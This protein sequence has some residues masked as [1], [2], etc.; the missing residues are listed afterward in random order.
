MM[1]RLGSRKAPEATTNVMDMNVESLWNLIAEQDFH[2][3]GRVEQREG[4]AI[5]SNHLHQT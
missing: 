5:E 4:G 1:R 3:Q 2:R